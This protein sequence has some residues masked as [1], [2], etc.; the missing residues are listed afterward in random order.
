MDSK[1][2]RYAHNL[3]RKEAALSYSTKYEREWHK[4]LSDRRERQVIKQ[5][6]SLIDEPIHKVLDMPCGAGRLTC[7][8]LGLNAE[9]TAADYSEEQLKI[10]R[11]RYEFEEVNICVQANCF[12]LPFGKNAFDLVFSVRLSHHIGDEEKRADYLEELFRVSHKFVIATFFDSHSLK[13]RV[14]EFRRRFLG[15]R[16]RSKFTLSLEQLKKIADSNGWDIRGAFSIAPLAS[17]H[18]YVVFK[19]RAGSEDAPSLFT[20][21]QR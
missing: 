17:G 4:R 11:S 13:N 12:E 7:E 1:M 9:I 8:L 3:Q 20:E 19:K 10:C 14:R 5:A 6:L 21:G 2:Q 18:K 15:A 16:K